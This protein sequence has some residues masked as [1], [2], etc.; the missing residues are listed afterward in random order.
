[1]A[2]LVLAEHSNAALNDVTAKTV[3]AAQAFGGGSGY[4]RHLRGVAHV[5]IDL[6]HRRRE[7]DAHVRLHERERARVVRVDGDDAAAVGHLD[8]VGAGQCHTNSYPAVS[9]VGSNAPWPQP[10]PQPRR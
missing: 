3:A 4:T 1:M 5:D 9:P 2:V 8:H 7:R 6:E 10:W